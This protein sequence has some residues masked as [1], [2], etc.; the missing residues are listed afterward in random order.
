MATQSGTSLPRRGVAGLVA[1]LGLLLVIAT[2]VLG[3]ET[4]AEAEGCPDGTSLLVTFSWDGTAFAP[5]GGD[6][7]GVAVS[8]DG[9]LAFFTSAQTISALVVTAGAE[10]R[11]IALDLPETVGSVAP[12]NYEV[13]GGAS[14][15]AIGF[16]TGEKADPDSGSRASIEVA[17]TATCATL[18]ADGTATV[19]GTIDVFNHHPND[20]RVTW[21]LDSVFDANQVALGRA[22]VDG[23]LGLELAPEATA[24]IPYTVTFDPADGTDFTNF[25]EV[26]IE[27]AESG[28]ARHKI[29]N[30][31][32]QFALCDEPVNPPPDNGEEPQN[33]PRGTVAGGNPTPDPDLPDTSMGGAPSLSIVFLVAMFLSSIGVLA[34]RVAVARRR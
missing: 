18:N 16:C 13:F 12:D 5:D 6:P 20:I 30:A 32:A 24:S 10:T 31:R 26:T 33:T 29:Y 3:T 34:Y 2:P 14:L 19:T 23:L 25:V 7:M 1:A 27:N 21:A 17:K 4:G 22:V 8:G 11:N 28:E 9:D 15:S